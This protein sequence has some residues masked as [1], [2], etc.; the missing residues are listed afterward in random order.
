MFGVVRVKKIRAAY[1]WRWR[2][3]VEM[4]GICQQ[5]FEQM[6]SECKHPREC[7]PVSGTCAHCY[8]RH[9]IETWVNTNT[10]CPI[11]R[12]EWREEELQ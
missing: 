11:C 8:H 9:C 1:K 4:C 3:P 10:D 12:S 5:P 7:A 6:C 2:T